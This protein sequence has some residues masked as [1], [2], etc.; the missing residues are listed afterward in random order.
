MAMEELARAG[1][2]KLAIQPT[3]PMEMDQAVSWA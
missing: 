1:T 3:V 2:N